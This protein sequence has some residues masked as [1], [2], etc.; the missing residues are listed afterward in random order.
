[1]SDAFF[2]H[3]TY[4]LAVLADGYNSA[5]EVW[6]AVKN[7]P[8]LAVID[9]LPAPRR[10]DF[11][12]GAP[13]PDFKL[14]GFYLE[15]GRMPPTPI[16]VTDPLTGE[17]FHL[18]IIGILPEVIPEYMIGVTTNQSFVEA[19]FPELA[20]PTAHLIGLNEGGGSGRGRGES[21]VGLPQQRYGSGSGFG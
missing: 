2:D 20:T 8:S 19:S 13:V 4:D 18:T 6:Q 7:D 11:G 21:G 17:V 12:F 16:E 15:D 3:T 5:E 9:G 14:E 10:D 1:M